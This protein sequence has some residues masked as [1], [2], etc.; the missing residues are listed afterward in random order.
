MAT[1][2]PVEQIEFERFGGGKAVLDSLRTAKI[3]EQDLGR[4][5][6]ICARPLVFNRLFSKRG[7][8][9]TVDNARFFTD[10]VGEIGWQNGTAFTY[11]IR[12]ESGD[13]VGAIDIKS[14]DR[15]Q[16][17][18]GYW[19]DEENPGYMTNACIAIC[20]AAQNAGYKKLF[21]EIAPDNEKSSG[22]IERAGFALI[23]VNYLDPKR[24]K[25]YK[26]Y[27]VNLY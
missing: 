23:D 9:Y 16:A 15:E 26:K 7:D 17:E 12:N 5:A 6:T 4:I 1:V 8:T 2:D 22:V 10:Q 18:V 11:V 25:P 21:A 24:N 3:T 13:I 14:G 20:T 27:E 19:A